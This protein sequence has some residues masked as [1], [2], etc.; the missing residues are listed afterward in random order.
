MPSR[1]RLVSGK[2]SRAQATARA[3]LKKIMKFA[4]DMEEPLNDAIEFVLAL[5]MI[6]D[7]MVADY[8]D[9]GRPIAAVAR[10]A[11]RRLQA[12][13]SAWLGLT[14]IGQGKTA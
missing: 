7:G 14:D 11:S 9:Q 5:R 8:D 10:A 6:G 12:L 13:E 1:K 3:R 2:P 4:L